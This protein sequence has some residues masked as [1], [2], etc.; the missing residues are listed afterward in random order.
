MK[1]LV[2]AVAAMS[3]V[4]GSA[5]DA[6]YSKPYKH[7]AKRY[8]GHA[9]PYSGGKQR[10]PNEY[11]WYPHDSNQLAVGS[12]IWWEQMEREGRLGRRN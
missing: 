7:H 3:L 10:Y 11:G 6:V 5:Y 1:P 4:A 8:V 12:Q 9:V 2:A